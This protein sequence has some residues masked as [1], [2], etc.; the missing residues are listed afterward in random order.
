MIPAMITVVQLILY[1]ELGTRVS[2]I[3]NAVANVNLVTISLGLFV[4]E[5]EE[6]IKVFVC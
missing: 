1:V 5:M 3:A 4:E 2:L 6:S